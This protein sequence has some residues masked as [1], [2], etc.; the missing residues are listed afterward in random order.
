MAQAFP[1]VH[2]LNIASEWWVILVAGPI[3]EATEASIRAAK[4]LA[5]SDAGAVEALRAVADMLDDW[6]GA[7]NVVAPTY[8]KFCVEL[9]LT[10]ASRAGLAVSDGEAS[11]GSRLA[12]LRAITG[13]RG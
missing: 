11:Q 2:Y 9:G 3:R 1:R 5:E 12:Q 7:D 4:H 10:P 13:G 6:D 8:L